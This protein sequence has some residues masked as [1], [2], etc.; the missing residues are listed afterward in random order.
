MV[1][2]ITNFT[3]QKDPELPSDWHHRACG[4][5][6]LKMLMDYW[7]SQNTQNQSA[8]TN[9]LLLQGLELNAYQENIGWKHVG[10]VNLAK[11][12]G[13]KGYN[14]DLAMITDSRAWDELLQD[15]QKYPLIVS[16]H[17]NFDKENKDGHLLVLAGIDNKEIYI[18]DPVELSKES[19]LKKISI[20]KFQNAWKK[21][22]LAIFP[23]NNH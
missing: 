10:L 2:Q 18:Y 20:E 7:Q 23:L 11:K 22:Y 8:A 3:S 1:Y 13:Y 12:F 6:S 21:R 15:L 17:S 16:V 19:G 9:D 4:V 14:Q 5:A